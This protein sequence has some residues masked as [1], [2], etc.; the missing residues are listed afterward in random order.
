MRRSHLINPIALAL[1]FLCSALVA[2][3]QT[4]QMRGTVKIVAADGQQA[5]VAGATVDVYRTDMK[6]D[7]HTKS[8]K[9]GEWVFAGLPFVGVY[10]VSISAPGASPMAKTGVRARR[11]TPVDVLL[12]PGTGKKL[13]EAEALAAGKEGPATNGATVDSAAEKA[14][15][16]EIAKKNA[17]IM[18]TNNKIENANKVIGDSFKA[19]NAALVAGNEA[20]RA[21]KHEEAL[22][23]YGDAIQQYDTGVAA[24][25]EHPG[26]AS[27]LTN[28]SAAL[29]AR[30]VTKYNGAILL[31]ENEAAKT[32]G[33]ESAKA[34]F[35]AAA[36][37]ATRAVELVKKQTPATDPA[38]QKQQ[39]ANKYFA[40]T[41][42]AEAMRLFVMKVDSTKASDAT[43]A[44]EEYSAVETDPA[45]KLKGEKD[46][47][48]MLFETAGD[49]A[50]YERAIGEYQ[51]ILDKT[52]DDPDSLL[53]I[54]QAMFNIG[55]LNNNDKAKYQE[56]SNY[57]Q[58]YVDKA[59]ESQLRTEAKELIEAM[60]AQANVTPEKTT[61]PAP[62]RK[63][64]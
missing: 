11:D 3:A 38:E 56:A 53:R 47:A 48:Q 59:P 29:R 49:V 18:A 62:A 63:R 25:P 43:A 40:L 22:K 42:R 57:L 14:K 60:K 6:A 23:L 13:T 24:D 33:I 58:R 39:A 45:K 54:G 41:A 34:D 35:T 10:T 20:D 17:E 21:N 12:A 32:A 7:Y 30:A 44:Y 15:A 52:P 2:S 8:D 28:K 26:I 1:I 64:P 31:K 46:F 50:G 55:A 16:A 19:G 4:E 27:L 37:A 5:P 9:K 61:R 36:E 51:K